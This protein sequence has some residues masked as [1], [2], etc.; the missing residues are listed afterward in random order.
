MNETLSVIGNP[1]KHSKSPLIHNYWL[2]KYN[3]KALYTKIEARKTELSSYIKMV[4]DKE[5]K[6][7]N[8]TLPFKKDFFNLVDEVDEAAK[9][10]LA[11]NTIFEKNGKIIGTNTDGIGFVS[12]LH[13]DVDFELK[14][15]LNLF[16]FGAGGAT[17]GIVSELLKY[18]PLSIEISNRTLS[19]ATILVNHF[20]RRKDNNTIFKVLPWGESP[21]EHIDMVVNTSTCGMK[22]NDKFPTNLEKLSKK[23]LVYDII[24]NPKVTSLMK[25]ARKNNLLA[26]NGIYMLVRQAAESF[27]RW[28][29]IDLSDEDIN[30]VIKLLGHDA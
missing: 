30:D 21:K 17:Y 5:L 28:F 25:V 10:S 3:I 23:A 12:S 22:E 24:Y 26:I 9:S 14:Y 6:G 1:I 4:K 13:R 18:K 11:I 8:V 15:G 29:E 16:C 2:K 20:S 19:K 27:K 7:L